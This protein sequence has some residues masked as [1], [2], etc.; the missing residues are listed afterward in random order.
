MKRSGGPQQSADA[1][2][3]AAEKLRDAT[4]LIGRDTAAT[5]VGQVGFAIA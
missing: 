5:G 4:S 3:Q 2:R 1:A